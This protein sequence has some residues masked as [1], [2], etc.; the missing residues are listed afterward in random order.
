M[1]KQLNE[2]IVCRS[3]SVLAQ[4]GDNYCPQAS[5]S[6]PQYFNIGLQVQ[7]RSVLW[8]SKYAKMRFRRGLH[9]GPRRGSSRPSLRPP[10]RL[11][12]GVD[13]PPHT[14][15]IDSPAFGASVLGEALPPQYFPL[16]PRL[17]VGCLIT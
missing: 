17:I 13:T 7:K 9:P 16:E 15:P 2:C 14:P 4:M 1:S 11:G 8:F 3:T 10:S 5:A 12:R 6:L